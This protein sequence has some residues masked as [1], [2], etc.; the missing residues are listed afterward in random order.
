MDNSLKRRLEMSPLGRMSSEDITDSVSKFVAHGQG[1]GMVG[2]GRS[3]ALFTSG[4][5]SQGMNA[6]V[7]SVVRM[8]IYVGF[9]V[10]CIQEGYQG[11]VNGGDCIKEMAWNGVSNIIQLGGTVIGSARCKDFREREGRKRAAFNLIEKNIDSLVVI[12]GDGS[13]TGANLF[14]QEWFS[15]LQ[16][17][18][19]EGKLDLQKATRFKQLHIV[20]MVGSIDNDFCGTDMTIGTDTALHRIIEAVDAISTTAQSHQRTFI[21]EVMG[22][23]C[24]YL[25]LVAGLA[26]GA[27]WVFI[28][29]KPAMDGWE[30]VLCNKLSE[31]RGFGQRL[32]ILILAEGAID[33]K[34]EPITAQ[35][36]KELIVERLQ[37]DTRIT[38]LGHVQRGGSPSAFDRIL[39]CRMGAEAV[40]ALAD[41]KPDSPACVV[42]L[43]GNKAVRVPLMSCVDKTQ[44]V[45]KAV[46]ER[47]FQKASDLRGKSFNN[48]LKT[49]LTLNKRKPSDEACTIDGK[50]CSSNFNI[51][52]MNIGAPASGMN[53][54][55]RGFVRSCMLKGYRV[56][57]VADGFS[58]LL[59]DDVKPLGWM[60]V[61]SW[62][63]EG[64]SNLGT[65]R[66]IP[67]KN[68]KE[69]ADKFRQHK[70]HALMIFGGFEGY[71][72]ILKLSD[73]RSEFAEFCIPM[74]LV[75]STISN[76]VPGTDF[77]LGCDTALNVITET[78]DRLKQSATGSRRRVFVVETMG[79][80]CG[81]LATMSGLAAGADAAYIFEEPFTIKDLEGDVQHMKAKIKDN[82]LRGIVLRN[83]KA[84]NNFTTTF[85]E[86][87]FQEE[88]KDV[89]VCRQ[90]VLGHVQQGGAPSPFD[91]NLGTKLAVKA[92]NFLI[93]QI[94]E[95]KKDNNTVYTKS[96][97]S[98]VIV[99]ICKRET[100]FTP[101]NYLQK[102]TDFKHRIPE[103]QWWMKLRPLLR[104]LAKH[105]STYEAD[106]EEVFNNHMT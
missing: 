7:R 62:V 22:R 61:A 26:S 43:D 20:G 79:G 77:S 8:G 16:E 48:N 59:N 99:G 83:E 82:I 32:N 101:V 49:Y 76:N 3:L 52:L 24:G 78:L 97:K 60:E 51:A 64:G 14:R 2:T 33:Q 84:N 4:G 102:A 85:I 6:A 95:N 103:K 58:G 12:G 15:F 104:I 68:C 27:D 42:S 17:F 34:G 21:L 67:D 13:L 56:L 37:F 73:E 44:A 47:N 36:V 53:P 96:E 5:D 57:G 9:K 28:P 72:S 90:N 11:M 71:Q 45:A 54:A 18:V 100:K 92:A 30:E 23:H 74:A 69:I 66:N 86:H 38:V 41:A 80:F 93:E 35:Y 106:C 31:S 89:Y 94:E 40:L 91:R 1:F 70:I 75:A 87:L 65:N 19:Q 88:G 25:A 39:G 81:Y 63:S 98:A 105:E 50:V 29:E 55:G 46:Q 10:Y